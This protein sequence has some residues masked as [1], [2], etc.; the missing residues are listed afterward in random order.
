MMKTD[1]RWRSVGDLGREKRRMKKAKQAEREKRESRDEEGKTKKDK[2]G[3]GKK[4]RGKHKVDTKCK[5]KKT[6]IITEKR[7]R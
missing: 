6:K 7:K 4:E 1:T 3:K 5:N 2:G